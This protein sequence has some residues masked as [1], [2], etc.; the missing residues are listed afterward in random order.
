MKQS[1]TNAEVKR[2]LASIGRRGG[3]RIDNGAN[4]YMDPQI[5]FAEMAEF[6]GKLEEELATAREELSIARKRVTCKNCKRILGKKSRR[7][8]IGA[9]GG[10]MND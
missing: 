1:R 5:R 10:K 7:K 9:Q 2:L 8:T 3:G 4:L 6:A